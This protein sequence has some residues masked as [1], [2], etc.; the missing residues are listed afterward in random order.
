MKRRQDLITIYTVDMNHTQEEREPHACMRSGDMVKWAVGSSQEM[1]IVGKIV[2]CLV[3]YSGNLVK[4]L[5]LRS[6]QSSVSPCISK[7]ARPASAWMKENKRPIQTL[8]RN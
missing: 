8:G 2:L 6:Q 1:Q 4:V 5:T 3:A 7:L